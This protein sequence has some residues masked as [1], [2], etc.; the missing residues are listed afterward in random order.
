MSG[1]FPLSM[2]M[3]KSMVYTNSSNSWQ[4]LLFEKIM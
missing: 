1:G 3:A 2:A 4:L